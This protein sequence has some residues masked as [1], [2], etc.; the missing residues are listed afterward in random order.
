MKGSA[1]LGDWVMSFSSVKAGNLRASQ[2][3]WINSSEKLPFPVDEEK[4]LA[5][6]YQGER[7]PLTIQLAGTGFL[8]KLAFCVRFPRNSNQML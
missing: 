5:G 3:R 8:E 4:I 2:S 1:R 6:R 7:L